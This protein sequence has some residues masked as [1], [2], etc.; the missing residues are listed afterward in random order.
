MTDFVLRAADAA[1]MLSAYQG[2]GIANEDGIRQSGTVP[3]GT[4]WALL[5]C[6][7]TAFDAGYLSVLRW[8][9]S[10]PTPPVPPSIEIIWTPNDAYEAYPQGLPRFA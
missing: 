5:D 3:D 7:P 1:T 10:T 8:N 4:T 6:G 9:G 2:V